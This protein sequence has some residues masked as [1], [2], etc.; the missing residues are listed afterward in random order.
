MTKPITYQLS[1][2]A[3][4]FHSNGK[5]LLFSSKTCNFYELDKESYDFFSDLKGYPRAAED[6][7][8]TEMFE[9]LRKKGILAYPE[10]DAL[11]IEHQKFINNIASFSTSA[12]SLTIAPTITCNLRCPYC[13]EESKPAGIMDKKI[14][15]AIVDY[16]K[17]CIDAKWIDITWFGGEPLLCPSIIDYILDKLNDIDGMKLRSHSIVTNGTL[18][19]EQAIELFCKHPL[20]SMQITLDGNKIRHDTKRFYTCGKGT[21]DDI[22][23]NLKRFFKKC[24]NTPVSI[25]VNI[26]NDNR[27][28]Y[29]EVYDI[30]KESFPSNN[31]S[32][33]PGIL[34]AN[35]GC[36][37]EV[38]FSSR[39][40]LEFMK[41]L[42]MQSPASYLYP[43]PQFKGCCATC[44][45][46]HVIGPQGEL[47]RCWEHV[48][49][50]EYVVG[51]ILDRSIMSQETIFR[52]INH[53]TLFADEECLKCLMLPIC[54]GG[55]PFRRIANKFEGENNELCSL[56]KTDKGKALEDMLF[57]YYELQQNQ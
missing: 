57:S 3:L 9:N 6:L 38:F 54:S 20:T 17:S 10:D 22:F 42:G 16:I 21:F 28:Q 19:N 35:K 18:L 48:G 39:D 36:E 15:D 1:Q 23:A 56:Y 55:C 52:Y 13:F 32:C 40:H 7:E 41:E 51:N 30:I 24:P 49:K 11:Y 12:V 43:K 14:A 34:R 44:A 50:I 47:Y 37:T 26:D 8:E 2:F 27:S 53:G 45:S 33:Y 31:I 4:P 5:Y 29:K 25:R 46:S